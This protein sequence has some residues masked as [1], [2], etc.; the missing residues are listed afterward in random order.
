M[1]QFLHWIKYSPGPTP[2]TT[3]NK[4][5]R[6]RLQYG[7][8]KYQSWEKNITNFWVKSVDNDRWEMLLVFQHCH[9]KKKYT[10]WG[11][12]QRNMCAFSCGWSSEVF[13]RWAEREAGLLAAVR[14]GSLQLKEVWIVLFRPV[15]FLL[16]PTVLH[17]T[18]RDMGQPNH[19][20][21]YFC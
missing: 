20:F 10:V 12:W 19:I 2:K 21:L 6:Q 4:I 11:N 16:D 9:L 5:I 17:P 1:T 13:V 15:P 3:T 7:I 8:Q 18:L 14:L